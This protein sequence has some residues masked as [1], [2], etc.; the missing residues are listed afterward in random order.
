MLYC[1][2]EMYIIYLIE[3]NELRASVTVALSNFLICN[4]ELVKQAY[5]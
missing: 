5:F 3:Y 2:I 4:D 1:F